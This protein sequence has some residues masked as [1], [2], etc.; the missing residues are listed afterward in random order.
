MGTVIIIIL[1]ILFLS[2]CFIGNRIS[3]YFVERIG[4]KITSLFRKRK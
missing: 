2:W 4:R 3:G 1:A